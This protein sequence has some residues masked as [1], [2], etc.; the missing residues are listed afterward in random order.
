MAKQYYP[1]LSPQDEL[2]IEAEQ[3][4]VHQKYWPHLDEFEGPNKVDSILFHGLHTS[5]D[6]KPVPV[7]QPKKLCFILG[8]YATELFVIEAKRYP[9]REFL[10]LWL[11]D[12]AQRVF[13]II[14]DRISHLP[15]LA[16]HAP[17]DV[18]RHAI[19]ESLRQG[20]NSHLQG[21]PGAPKTLTKTI[22]LKAP[23]AKAERRDLVDKFIT[24]VMDS[25]G[26]K[27]KRTDIWKVAGYTNR[28]EFERYQRG[29]TRTTNSAKANFSRIL[30]MEPVSFVEVLDKR[31]ARS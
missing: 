18:T 28:T 27:I 29:D 9:K 3:T 20:T 21:L 24:R 31:Q 12:L 25:T 1:N 7:R 30:A 5:S 8:S 11:N 26:R 2:E 14:M 16:Y 6:L 17:E 13:D 23:T 22:R 4:I 10:Q 15:N 19:M